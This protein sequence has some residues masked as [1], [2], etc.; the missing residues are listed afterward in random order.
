MVSKSTGGSFLL[1]FLPDFPPSATRCC[2]LDLRGSPLSS[3]AA[4]RACRPSRREVSRKGRGASPPFPSPAA[5]EP[6]P[7]VRL[8]MTRNASSNLPSRPARAGVLTPPA[9]ALLFLR[10]ADEAGADAGAPPSDLT[11]VPSG[12]GGMAPSSSAA[13]RP[14][15]RAGGRSGGP[16][17]SPSSAAAG[18]AAPPSS[19]S[20][21]FP[22]A[23]ARSASIPSNFPP[24]HRTYLYMATWSSSRSASVRSAG[25]LNTL[26]GLRLLFRALSLGDASAAFPAGAASS[27]G[28]APSAPAAPPTAARTGTMR[29][30]SPSTSNSIGAWG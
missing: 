17:S 19:P 13:A 26:A 8:G 1:L 6:D 30:P 27:S 14:S 11:G 15:G 12:G 5:S 29:V 28:I 3:R 21:V 23:A 24:S 20:G 22:P 9:G 10:L 4:T 18:G 2:L 7:A 25:S 16:S